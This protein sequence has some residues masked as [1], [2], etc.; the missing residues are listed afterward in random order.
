[1]SWDDFIRLA[2]LRDGCILRAWINPGRRIPPPSLTTFSWQII[3]RLH[4]FHQQFQIR[5]DL[6]HQHDVRLKG[7]VKR[8]RVAADRKNSDAFHSSSL[9]RLAK[10]DE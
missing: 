6:R 10:P 7:G 5:C 4:A 8:G 1:M 9:L 3:Q 2:L